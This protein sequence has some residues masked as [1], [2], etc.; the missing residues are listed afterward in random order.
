M[1]MSDF[2]LS[3]LNPPNWG[4]DELADHI[5][6]RHHRY[7]QGAIPA[8][9]EALDVAVSHWGT[10]HA[11]LE[12]VRN[13]FEELAD[14]LESHMAKEEHILFPAIREMARAKRAGRLSPVASFATLAHPIR[15]MEDEH[16]HA[17]NVLT[18]LRGETRSYQPPAEADEAGREC[19]RQLARFDADLQLHIHLEND[20]LFPSTLELEQQV[21]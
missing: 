19:Y 12:A 9:R 13:L 6:D 10:K 16:A 1:D 18:S 11:P 15:A 4:L 17:Q 7:V 3:R 20:V 14:E 2:D 8:L 21:A 5:V